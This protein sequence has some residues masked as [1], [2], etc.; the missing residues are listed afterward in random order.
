M[1]TDRSPL[2]RIFGE[3]RHRWPLMTVYERFEQIVALVL[4]LIGWPRSAPRKEAEMGHPRL[5]SARGLRS[6]HAG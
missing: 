6:G 4:S 1:E 3:T 2:T 5:G